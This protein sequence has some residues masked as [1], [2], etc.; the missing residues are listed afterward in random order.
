MNQE[1]FFSGFDEAPEEESRSARKREAQAIRQLAEEICNLGEQ[2]YKAL[3]MPADVKAA[4]D[5]ARRLRPRS[6]ER[7]RQLQYAAKQLRRFP[8]NTLRQQLDLQ[9]ASA[10]EDPNA[11]RLEHLRAELI[12]GGKDAIN[13]FVALINDTDRNKLRNFVKKAALEQAAD[14]GLPKPASRALYRH[15]KSEFARAKLQIPAT[16]KGAVAAPPDGADSAEDFTGEN[17]DDVQ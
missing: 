3:D 4:I 11:M 17:P 15:I 13:A 16:L 5:E 2:S 12:E 1:Q 9:G 10:K 6:D 14:P 7:R 8:E